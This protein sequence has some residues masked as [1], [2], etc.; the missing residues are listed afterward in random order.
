MLPSEVI[1]QYK[2][3]GYRVIGKNKHSAV[4]ICRWTKSA[5]RGGKNCYKGWFGIKSHRCVQMTPCIL[6]DL[7]CQFCW[8]RSGLKRTALEN[9]D[10]PKEIVDEAIKI[11]QELIS[12]FGGNEKTTK[13]LFKEARTP[14]HFAISLD[15]EPTLY[16]NLAD[17]IKEIKSRDC[18]VFLVTN[19]TIPERL[20]E[21]IEKG[22][23]PTNLYI[24]IYGTNSEDYEKICR[25]F[26]PD[27][28]EKVK[29]SL[30]LMKEFKKS[31]KIFRITA[32]KNLNMKNPEEYSELIKMSEPDFVE[33]K[34]YAWLGESRKRLKKENVPTMEHL[35]E[36]AKELEKLT[37]YSIKEK[38]DVSRVVLMSK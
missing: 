26:I 25:P 34:G 22:A 15:G 2:K 29:E 18:T 8:R 38:D 21:L 37:G 31:R 5:L 32:V 28:F 12:G 9:W 13:Q 23:E 19:G 14:K 4:E 33:L 30:K 36:F 10:N 3:S 17:L 1:K 11:Q 35:E 27:A 6:C 20:K 7:S 24:S 16:P